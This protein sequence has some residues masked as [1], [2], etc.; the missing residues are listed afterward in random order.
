ML[1]GPGPSVLLVQVTAELAVQEMLR[2]IAVRTRA[3]TGR[4]C[5]YAED[6]LD[7]GSKIQLSV[8]IDAAEVSWLFV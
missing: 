7:D 3:A 2:E 4:T 8:D 5:L 1:I 6:F